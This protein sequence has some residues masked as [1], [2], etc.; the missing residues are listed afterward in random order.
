MLAY[1]AMGAGGIKRTII[2]FS[3]SIWA[4]KGLSEKYCFFLFARSFCL[5]TAAAAKKKKKREEGE[6]VVF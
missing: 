6:G 3:V 2:F 1:C 5:P 4:V